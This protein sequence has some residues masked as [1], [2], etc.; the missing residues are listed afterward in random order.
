MRPRLLRAPVARLPSVSALTGLP[1]QTPSRSTRTSWRRPGVAGL[2]VLSAISVSVLA[3]EPGGDVD[4]VALFEGHER[5]LDVAA[6][7]DASG[8]ALGLALQ[9]QRV[10]A[11]H[12]DVEE[13]LHRFLDLRLVRGPRDA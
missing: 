3:L 4:R 7:A 6:D 8:E 12:L 11:L 10:D 13:L 2:Y 9:N 5:F 1:F